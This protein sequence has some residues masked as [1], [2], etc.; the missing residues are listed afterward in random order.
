MRRRFRAIRSS[1]V[2]VHL[3][4]RGNDGS[5]RLRCGSVKRL[6]NEMTWRLEITFI[7]PEIRGWSR[8]SV[9]T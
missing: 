2:D 1:F 7:W 6:E 8:G 4:L 3:S 5:R 9:Y